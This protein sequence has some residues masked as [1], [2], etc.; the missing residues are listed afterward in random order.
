MREFETLIDQITSWV[1]GPPLLIVLI[2]TGLYLTLLLRGVQ[3]RYLGLALKEM[4]ADQ[5][6][7][8]RGDISQFEAL[9]TT[10]AGA[11]GTGSI[12]GVATAVSLGGF[13]ALVWMWVTAG[14]GMATKYAEGL[15]AV[16][17]RVVDERGEMVGGPMEYMERGLGWKKLAILFAFLGVGASLGTGNLVQVNSIAAAVGH[18]TPVSPW[19]IGIV[20]S[21]LTGMILIGGVKSV[22][23]IAAVLVPIM[24]LLYFCGGV[25]ILI[26]YADRLPDAIATIFS[27]AFSGQAA[28][29]GFAGATFMMGVQQGVARGAFTTEAGLGISSI[30]AAAARTD[31]PVRQALVNMTGALLVVITCTVT[32]LVIAVTDVLGAHNAEGQF[33]SGAS[34]AITAFSHSFVFG[35]YIVIIGLILFA[36]TTAIAWAYYGEKCCEYLLGARFVIPFRILYTCLVIPGAA[37]DMKVAWGIADIMNGLMAWPN[38]VALVALSPV[39]L[40]ETRHFLQRTSAECVCQ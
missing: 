12:V 27:S 23:R 1:W 21:C 17:Y 38:L 37:I 34:I 11:I 39:L 29:G 9:M 32:G 13:G 3:F 30:A 8:A 19:L 25:S 6:R 15:L 33:L 4:M 5:K 10:L 35:H 7:G 36:Y 14:V 26:L 31:S 2:G 22:G 28:F 20:L 40:K 24:A 16:K 18:L